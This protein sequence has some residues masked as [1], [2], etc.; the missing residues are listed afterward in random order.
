MYYGVDFPNFGVFADHQLLIELA[1]EAEQ[2]GWD[3]FFL[4]DHLSGYGSVPMIDPW[5]AMTAIALN[6]SRVKFGPMVTPLARRR[7]WKVAREAVSLD[8]LS[9][10]RFILGVG[11]GG[12][13]EEWENLGDPGDARERADRLD[14]ALE[15]LVGLWSGESLSYTGSYYQVKE[16]VFLPTPLQTPRIPI[17][18]AG[19]WPNKPPMRRAARWDGAFPIGKGLYYDQMMTPEAMK[20]V[21]EYVKQQRDSSEPCDIIHYGTTEGKER[22]QDTELVQKYAEIGITWWME[23][24]V[25]TRWGDWENWSFEE[26]RRRLRQGPPRI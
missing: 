11:T 17:W 7:P 14:E 2:A 23:N 19:R 8:R 16:E 18:V 1:Q 13:P 10:G 22:N 4:W 12:R 20:E 25:P 3:G 5:V 24:M 9:N 21:V 26:M 6:T 15:I